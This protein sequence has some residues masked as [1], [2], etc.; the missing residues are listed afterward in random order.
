MTELGQYIYCIIGADEPKQFESIG[1]DDSHPE[2]YTVNYEGLAAVVSDSP[3]KTYQ[4]SRANMMAHQKV[5]EEAMK[6]HTVLPVKF[7]T[8]AEKKGMI[9]EKVLKRRYKEFQKMMIDMNG[10]T[11]HGLKMLWMDIDKVFAQIVEENEDIK[12]LRD[13][14]KWK[15]HT[16]IHY[17][18]IHVGEMVEAALKEKKKNFVKEIVKPLKLLAEDCRENDTHGDKM[19]I[20]ASFLVSEENQSEFD[21]RIGELEASYK[22]DIKIK[23]VGPIPPFNFVEIV[24]H[25]D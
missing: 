16:K 9:E 1:I 4:L 7:C 17:D 3:V 12:G 23:Y 20:N 24:V 22:E 14:L 6:G 19:I 21:N 10:K 11:E 25:W 13:S 2:I 8:I 18:M 15:P 5:C